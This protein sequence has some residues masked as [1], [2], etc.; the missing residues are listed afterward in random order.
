MCDLHTVTIKGRAILQWRL[1]VI[2]IVGICYREINWQYLARTFAEFISVILPL[3]SFP[4]RSLSFIRWLHSHF[5]F[6]FLRRFCILFSDDDVPSDQEIIDVSSSLLTKPTTSAL[7]LID[8]AKFMIPMTRI[9]YW[10]DPETAAGSKRNMS[11]VTLN[12]IETKTKH[13]SC[14]FSSQLVDEMSSDAS[15]PSPFDD[16]FNDIASD[17]DDTSE[18]TFLF[19]G[20]AVKSESSLADNCIFCKLNNSFG[21]AQTT[22]T[23]FHAAQC[24]ELSHAPLPK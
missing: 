20:R 11:A 13:F 16:G 3:A 6:R 19:L 12:T 14:L 17:D 10:Y 18:L 2:V 7:L 4:G 22:K 21:S 23:D 24:S 9:C 15:S 8:I 5:S 1:F